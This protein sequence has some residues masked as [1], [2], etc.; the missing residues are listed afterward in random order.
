MKK[1]IIILSTVI[2][3][4]SCTFHIPEVENKNQ[5][6]DYLFD[7]T[8]VG[9]D[10]EAPVMFNIGELKIKKKNYPHIS[11]IWENVF[12]E[13]C[14]CPIAFDPDF[15]WAYDYNGIGFGSYIMEYFDRNYTKMYESKNKSYYGG[16]HIYLDDTNNARLYIIT[17]GYIGIFNKYSYLEYFENRKKEA[18]E[19]DRKMETVVN[20][21]PIIF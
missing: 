20:A 21:G 12:G 4:V 15:V 7:E 14:G 17:E 18:D 3:A 16:V 10:F 13:V 11:G 1:F 9:E 2:L 5:F 19:F 6:L 8:V